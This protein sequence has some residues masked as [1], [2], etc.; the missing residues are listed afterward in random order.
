MSKILLTIAIGLMLSGVVT[1]ASAV[2][3][4]GKVSCGLWTVER[5]ENRQGS[6]IWL[7]GFLS[8]TV[9]A[10]GKD[11]LDGTDADSLNLWM[12]NYCK[13]NPLKMVNDGAG[14]LYNELKKQKNIK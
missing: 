5:T 9:V 4:M 10:T 3:L 13:A 7:M 6:K 12:D 1:S 14:V 2:T 11:V 8:G